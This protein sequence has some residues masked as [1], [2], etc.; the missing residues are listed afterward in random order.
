M[1]S[2]FLCPNKFQKRQIFQI[3]SRNS[4]FFE[5]YWYCQNRLYVLYLYAGSTLIEILC[6]SPTSNPLFFS[7]ILSHEIDTIYQFLCFI[8]WNRA[9]IIAP[10]SICNI[11]IESCLNKFPAA[12][13]IIFCS[14]IFSFDHSS[15][16][17]FDNPFF[18]NSQQQGI[19]RLSCPFFFLLFKM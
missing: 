4:A 1:R 18:C 5:I 10:Y 11:S 9:V 3:I 14:G 19:E 16:R 7:C 15:L 6:H 12:Q 2:P 8:F 17:S 13:A